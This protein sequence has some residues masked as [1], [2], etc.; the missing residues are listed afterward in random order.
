[1]SHDHP[2]SAIL[3][4]S[5]L[6]NPAAA[7]PLTIMELW[8]RLEASEPNGILEF[9]CGVST[10]VLAC[11]ARHRILSGA[12]LPS[13]YSVEH[14]TEWI[15]IVGRRL[16]ALDLAS[17]VTL[18]E[19]PLTPVI[20]GSARI[21]C[22]APQPI[23]AVVPA[24]SI[25]FCIIDGPPALQEPLSRLGCLPLASPLLRPGA[26][27]L[28]DDVG[29]AGERQAIARWRR[30]FPAQIV[31]LSAVLTSKGFASFTWRDGTARQPPSDAI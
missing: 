7:T 6:D 10:C 1:L 13:V 5:D 23:A 8:D 24:R 2:L 21:H 18:V 11:Y 19:A 14:S 16:E 4:P 31:H 17:Y 9:G 30:M 27:V 12:S 28:V 20:I 29:R 3:R 26:A 22:Y 25:D 15:E